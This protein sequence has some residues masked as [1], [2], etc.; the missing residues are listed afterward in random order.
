MAQGHKRQVERVCWNDASEVYGCVW[1]GT[2]KQDGRLRYLGLTTAAFC[3]SRERDDS[4]CNERF[5]SSK[6]SSRHEKDK[7][8]RVFLHKCVP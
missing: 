2:G 5:P 8:G 1:E 6:V 7:S 4:K 3:S